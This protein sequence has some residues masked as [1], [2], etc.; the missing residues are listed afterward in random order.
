MM[1]R[2]SLQD[3]NP[4]GSSLEVVVDLD[5]VGFRLK[6]CPHCQ[7][8]DLWRRQPGDDW[9]CLSCGFAGETMQGSL[10]DSPTREGQPPRGHAR[11]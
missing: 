11:P 2:S 10:P 3:A 4:G 8:G 6:C 7:T 5:Y 1:A 9:E